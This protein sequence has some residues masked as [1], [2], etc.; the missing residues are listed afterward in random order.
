MK[1]F[2]IIFI[3][4]SIFLP[5]K[6]Q[7]QKLPDPP[8]LVIFINIDELHTEHLLAFKKKFGKYG[9][10]Q[11]INNG[12]FYHKGNFETPT[13]FI[14]TKL[15]NM[16]C[17]CY[18]TT[19][20]IISDLWY[21]LNQNLP[22]EAFTFTN[23]ET[24]NYPDSGVIITPDIHVSS[25]ADELKISNSGQSKI[26]CVGLTPKDVAFFANPNKVNSYWFDRTKGNMVTQAD[27]FVADWITDFNNKRFSDL[28]LSRQWGP[29]A[30]LK[31][32][33]EYE[34]SVLNNIQPRHF[35]YDLKNSN[36]ALPYAHI[37]GSPYGNIILRDFVAS[38][39]INE[40]YGKDEY[41]DILSISFTC[42]PFMK[43]KYDLF[44]AEVEDMILRLDD[45]IESLINLTKDNIGIEHVLFVLTSTPT[46]RWLPETL[47]KEQ[48][49]TGYFNGKKTA[50][51]L[52]LYLMAIYGQGK[53]VKGYHDKQFYFNKPLLKESN[54]SL[55]EVQDKASTFLLEVAGIDK[56][57]SAYLLRVNDYSSGDFNEVQKN[58]FYGRSGDLFISL[59]PGWSEEIIQNKKQTVISGGHFNSPL[60]FFGWNT[61]TF[62]IFNSIKMID[63]APTIS[64]IL[65]I[66][67]P[68]GCVGEPLKDL[69][70]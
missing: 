40:N 16:V 12:A 57:I 51:L 41:T 6:T 27:T 14:G 17:G 29:I 68:N 47:K 55:K 31:K 37:S 24:L 3:F 49:N 18:P 42:K 46:S 20:G 35:L 23:N 64:T 36:N 9:F 5:S 67:D 25:I 33:H 2:L 39:I 15:A 54:I 50:S 4:L 58:Y 11:L 34:N 8:K 32:Y 62:Q 7:T 45:Q 21:P 63:V 59:K 65:Q 38:L 69:I 48:L 10:N 28:Y 43:D 30:D 1:S 22:K 52:N 60:I 44:D 26:A 61:S 19:H 66:P 70:K 13:S 53:W 56:T